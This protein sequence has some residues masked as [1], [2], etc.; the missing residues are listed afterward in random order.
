MGDLFNLN[1]MFSESGTIQSLCQHLG[2]E[3]NIRE[4]VCPLDLRRSNRSDI[5]LGTQD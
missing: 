5:N 3:A 4:L 1:G 2:G